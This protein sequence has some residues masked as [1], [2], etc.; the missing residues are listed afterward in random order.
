MK[1]LIIFFCFFLNLNISKADDTVEEQGFSYK[2]RKNEQAPF[3]GILLD[4]E[5]IALIQSKKKAD[6][7]IAVLNCKTEKDKEILN[8]EEKLAKEVNSNNSSKEQIEVLKTKMENDKINTYFYVAG[9][10]VITI[11]A[12]SFIIWVSK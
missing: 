9:S 11:A 4:Y 8:L 6:I 12:T 2:I 3:D 10:V 5:S 1:Y 7:K